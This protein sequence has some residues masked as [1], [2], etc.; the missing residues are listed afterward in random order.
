MGKLL[1][2]LVMAIMLG[3]CSPGPRKAGVEI[4]TKNTAKVFIN[5]KEAGM[6]PY[7]NLGLV[8]GDL[9]VKLVFE[10]EV[11]EKTLKLE[12]N[13]TTVVDW[14]DEPESNGYV[15]NLEETGDREMAGLL[16]NS[17]PDKALVMVDGEVLGYSP[18]GLRD[19]GAGDKQIKI[20]YPGFES[21]TLFVKSMAGYRLLI[22]AKLPRTRVE[23]LVG[24]SPTAGVKVTVE[25]V[26]VKVT[27]TG[28]LRV[29][30]RAGSG[31]R[32][33][34]RVYPGEKFEVVRR[35]AGWVG[36]RMEG[37][38]VGWVASSYVESG[39]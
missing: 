15:L 11:W 33:I 12:R 18:L 34:G 37:G 8:P 35:E 13:V 19:I 32:E 24:P 17:D 28:W 7:K 23:G 20:S 10:K 26:K 22:E 14:S 27:E 6:T 1:L 3:G 4:I 25:T 38:G 2:V 21:K 31:S 30:E 39:E 16:V 29:R 9:K 5:G 36:I